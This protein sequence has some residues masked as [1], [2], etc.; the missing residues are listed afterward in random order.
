MANGDRTG[1]AMFR[2]SS[3]YIGIHK[4]NNAYTLVYVN[5]LLLTDS[6]NGWQ[7]TAKGTT[8]QSR[9]L[10]GSVVWLRLI[11]DSTPSGNTVKFYYST[12]GSNFATF[13]DAFKATTGWEFFEG[14]RYAIFNFAT[15]AL[16]GSVTV[17][18]FELRAGPYTGAAT[19]VSTSTTITTTTT[20]TRTTTTTTTTSSTS[21]TPTTTTTS[22]TTLPT[23][24]W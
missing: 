2:E 14:A 17:N 12:D 5:N 19:G 3:A 13:G 8:V 4:V 18:N 1:F 21:T 24:P 11:S 15:S 16:G 10:N 20:T 22:P 9:A 6:D 7:T 23:V